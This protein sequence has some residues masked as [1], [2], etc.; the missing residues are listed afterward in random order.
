MQAF[1]ADGVALI[2]QPDH[3]DLVV[4]VEE[5]RVRPV[6][7]APM[8]FAPLAFA[9]CPLQSPPGL[10]HVGIVDDFEIK[11]VHHSSP[12]IMAAVRAYP[13]MSTRLSRLWRWAWRASLTAIMHRGTSMGMI[14]SPSRSLAARMPVHI[15]AVRAKS[16]DG[17]P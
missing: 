15:C 7:A 8:L 3:L 16:C 4:E 13:A 10:H 1:L 14:R 5:V 12:A 9:A 6:L 2:A 11:V 17:W